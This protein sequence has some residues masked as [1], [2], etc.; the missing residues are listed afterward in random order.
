MTGLGIFAIS[1]RAMSQFD[2][3]MDSGLVAWTGFIQ[4]LGTGMVFTPVSVLAFG[5][6]TPGLRPDAAGF[7]ALLRS[8]GNSAGISLLQA[9]YTGLVQTV[10]AGLVEGL[11]PDNAVARASDVP[12]SFAGASEAA[13]MA[14][15]VEVTRQA[16]MVAYV[17]LYHLL[18]LGSLAV[19]PVVLFLRPAGQSLTGPSVTAKP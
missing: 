2:L 4:G 8:V 19:M 10:H 16:S 14:Q 15:N 18:F 9:T 12:A 13:M 7:F 11:S 3:S 5:T 1:F 17:D 6:L